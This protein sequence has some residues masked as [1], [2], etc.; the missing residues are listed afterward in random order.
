MFLRFSNPLNKNDDFSCVEQVQSESKS[1]SR[2]C[3]SDC[4]LR[5]TTS[6]PIDDD[7]FSVENEYNGKVDSACRVER[8]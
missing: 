4:C 5:N 1:L 8:N 2:L 6:L 3:R 7:L